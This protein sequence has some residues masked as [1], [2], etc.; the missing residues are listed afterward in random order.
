DG[1]SYEV[2]GG[3]LPALEDLASSGR[4]WTLY[5]VRADQR[6]RTPGSWSRSLA[7]IARLEAGVTI[8]Q[9]RAQ[10]NQVALALEQAHP[11]WNRDSRVGI[12]PLHDYLVGAGTQSW[13]LMLLGAVAIVLVIAC[14]NVASLLLVRASARFRD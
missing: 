10:M 2:V 1:E 3:T 13:L 6:T 5:V 12:L 14:A 8:E 11:D 7:C 9:A 4:L